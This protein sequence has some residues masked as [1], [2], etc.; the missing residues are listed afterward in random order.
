MDL[1]QELK[2]FYGSATFT[3]ISLSNCIATEGIMYLIEKANCHWLISDYAIEISMTDK[4]KKEDF[5]VLK[6]KVNDDKSANVE[7]TDGNENVL[8]TKKYGYTDFPIKEFSFYIAR[9]ETGGHTFL[10]K[11]EY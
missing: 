4:L 1:E 11:G 5:I 9:N 3:R 7:L 8:H 6:I 10:L 2:Q